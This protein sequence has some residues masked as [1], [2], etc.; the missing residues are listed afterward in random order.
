MKTLKCK[1]CQ[2]DMYTKVKKSSNIGGLIGLLMAFFLL[3]VF[4]IGTVIAFILFFLAPF[5]GVTKKGYWICG[6][7]KY[8]IDRDI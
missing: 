8:R 6:K 7:C 1:M 4:P 2:G 3:F 5:Y